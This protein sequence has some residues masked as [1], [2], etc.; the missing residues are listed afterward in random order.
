LLATPAYVADRE[1]QGE[2]T[3][4]LKDI[5]AAKDKKKRA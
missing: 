4:P 3:Y 5:L 2:P 1:K